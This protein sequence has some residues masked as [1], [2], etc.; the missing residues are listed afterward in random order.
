MDAGSVW[1]YAD[2]GNGYD[3]NAYVTA[4]NGTKYT[5]IVQGSKDTCWINASMAA[6]ANKGVDLS[7]KI[8]YLGNEV[9]RVDLYNRIDNAHPEYG[10][11][12]Q[13]EYVT[14]DG[15]TRLADPNRPPNQEGESW[16][17]ILQR[18]IIQAVSRFDPS[19]NLDT[20]HSGGA[21]DALAI[22]TGTWSDWVSPSNYANANDLGAQVAA[23]KLIVASTLGT[24]TATLQ[25]RHAYT[26]LAASG[27]YVWLW[28][29]QGSMVLISWEG[30]M[31]DVSA[32]GVV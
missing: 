28:N 10:Y 32:L 7:Q 3:F 22:L 30:F 17:T 31:E 2:G 16:V 20:P 19:Q 25:A 29:P 9:Y 15:S 24:G 14:F 27:D 13:P 11:R 8:T 18:G 1:E 26:V 4:V 6:M 12:Y 21:I 23:G 5:D